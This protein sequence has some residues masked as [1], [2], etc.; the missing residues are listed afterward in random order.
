PAAA[1]PGGGGR[2]PTPVPFLTL[3]EAALLEGAT[4]AHLPGEH[5]RLLVHLAPALPLAPAQGAD[6]AGRLAGRAGAGVGL[7]VDLEIALLEV[8]AVVPLDRNL[9]PELDPRFP[10]PLPILTVT[11]GTVGQH[12]AHLGLQCPARLLRH[13]QRALVVRRAPHQD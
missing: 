6:L 13:L 8:L 4:G 3:L 12:L 1:P 11:E 10:E 9:G 7:Q 5:V 2:P